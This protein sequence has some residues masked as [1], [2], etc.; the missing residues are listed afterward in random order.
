MI[1][2]ATPRYLLVGITATFTALTLW[3]LTQTGYLGFWRDLLDGPAGWQVIADLAVAL[4]FVLRWMHADAR[5]AGRRFPPWL[6]L[7]L[8]AGSIGPLFYLLTA[9]RRGPDPTRMDASS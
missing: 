6:L 8:V 7:T 9:D 4:T 5:R 1:L 3:T 2:D